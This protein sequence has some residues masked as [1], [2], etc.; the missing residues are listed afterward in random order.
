MS[1]LSVCVDVNPRKEFADT[2][3]DGREID[4]AIAVDHDCPGYQPGHIGRL[5]L[6][7][8]IYYETQS[9]YKSI[10]TFL[11]YCLVSRDDAEACVHALRQTKYYYY[12]YYFFYYF[13]PRYSIPTS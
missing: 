8:R 6:S 11:D 1:L 13:A 12:D 9:G 5:R 7:F 10:C 3:A 4:V 2:C